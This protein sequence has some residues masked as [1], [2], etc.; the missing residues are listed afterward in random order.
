MTYKRGDVVVDGRSIVGEVEAVDVDNGRLT[1]VR[2]PGSQR[3][4]AQEVLCRY[5]SEAE[6]LTIRGEPALRVIGNNEPPA[7]RQS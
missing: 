5:A 7:R 6:A 2:P 4:S 3:W 1:L